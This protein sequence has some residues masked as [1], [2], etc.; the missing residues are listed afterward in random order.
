LI[1]PRTFECEKAIGEAC[2]IPDQRASSHVSGETFWAAV[3]QA[4]NEELRSTILSS[5]LASEVV[6]SFRAIFDDYKMHFALGKDQSSASLQM[7]Q[8]IRDN[9]RG[10]VCHQGVLSTSGILVG[11][12]FERPKDTT[13]S[14]TWKII[15]LALLSSVSLPCEKRMVLWGGL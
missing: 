15:A 5:V 1:K 8:H 11:C 12:C 13:K 4:L 10:P 9:R 14:C 6:P 7:G 2:L 3:E